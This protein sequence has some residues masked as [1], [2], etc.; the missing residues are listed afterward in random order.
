MKL[1]VVLA[2][3]VDKE[4]DERC[5]KWEAS[6]RGPLNLKPIKQKEQKDDA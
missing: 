3:P 2:L 5:A 4:A 1:I 6:L